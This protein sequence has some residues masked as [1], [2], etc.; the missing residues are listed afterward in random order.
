MWNSEMPSLDTKRPVRGPISVANDIAVESR[1]RTG[2]NPTRAYVTLTGYSARYGAGDEI[3]NALLQGLRS[4]GAPGVGV[5]VVAGFA[6]A[7]KP[8]NM[9]RP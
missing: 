7:A 1:P 2:S 9:G 8:V 3:G 5:I 6:P 4:Y